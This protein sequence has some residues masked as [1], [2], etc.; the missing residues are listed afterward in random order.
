MDIVVENLQKKVALNRPQIKTLVT[1]ILRHEAVKD[2]S[3]SVV[4]VTRQKI[5]ALNKQFLKRSYATDVLSFDLR[6]E[7][8]DRKLV[9]DIIISTDAVIKN[10][11][12][13][14]TTVPKELT[15]YVI[16][17]ILHLLGYDDHLPK[18]IARMRRKE[19][20]LLSLLKR[21]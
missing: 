21:T 18:D 6:Q 8:K 13:Y 9:G 10:A 12:I 16:H 11:K 3:L 2:Y 14:K 20:K 1:T 4:F 5:Q 17:G 19:E 15:L 7:K